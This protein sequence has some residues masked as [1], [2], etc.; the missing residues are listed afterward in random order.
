M[1]GPAKNA[2]GHRYGLNEALKT[3]VMQ[4]GSFC[5]GD[6]STGASMDAY[7]SADEDYFK[8]PLLL[9]SAYYYG[10]VNICACINITLC[11]LKP[12]KYCDMAP[13]SQNIG[14]REVSWRCC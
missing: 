13:K 2:K 9:Y 3:T 6:P 7:V 12:I 11:T 8:H 4:S 5:K 10:Q 14:V 1:F